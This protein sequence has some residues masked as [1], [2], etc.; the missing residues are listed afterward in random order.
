MV[1]VVVVVDDSNSDWNSSRTAFGSV[2]DKWVAMV[3]FAV[4]VAVV[5]AA[6]ASVT[7]SKA[8]MALWVSLSE[9]GCH[10]HHHQQQE[11]H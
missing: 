4:V 1:V 10:L 8:S 9:P 2:L 3:V 5:V 6:A 7:T 11:Y